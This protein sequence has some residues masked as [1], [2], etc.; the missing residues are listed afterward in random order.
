MITPEQ[1]R[2]ELARREL[3]RRGKAGAP[4]KPG[5]LK[6]G[7]EALKIPEQKSRQ[8]LEMLSDVLKPNP[9]ITGNLARDILMNYPSVE[10]KI[11][12]KAAPPFISRGSLVTAGLAPAFKVAG[13]ALAPVGKTIAS[14]LE[15]W[16]G[17]RPEGS[18]QTAANDASLIFSKGKNAASK[19]YKA[20]QEDIETSPLL[21]KYPEN[22]GLVKAAYREAQAGRLSEGEALEARKAADELKK[23]RGINKTWL[24]TRRK[25]FDQIAKQSSDVT[26][27]DV[28]YKRG[29][30]AEALRSPF[31]KN[32][33]G[34]ASPFKVGEALALAH[35]GPL[36]KVLGALFSPL[37]LGS[38]ATAGGV[39][40]RIASNPRAAV[41]VRQALET[42]R[43]SQSSSPP[44]E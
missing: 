2:A 31:P 40:G 10:A 39:A 14:S 5:V 1:A 19:Y 26:Q 18:L 9:E 20:L 35:L 21:N 3:A 28:A 24:A 4:S 25:V 6:R 23:S 12:S 13:K 11:A 44:S 36:G 8:G 42:L 37:A 30:M 43:Q 29:L 38:L 22:K 32:I 16:A 7:W 15:D 17:I 33:G 41:A 27:G 34:R